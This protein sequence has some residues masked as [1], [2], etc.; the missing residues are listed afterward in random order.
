[1]EIDDLLEIESD[2]RILD[3]RFKHNN[4]PM[5]LYVRHYLFLYI[6][7]EYYN[8]EN[9]HVKVNPYL[10]PL[11]KKLKYLWSVLIRH[12]FR[13]NRS[14]VLII[15]SSVNCVRE[16]DIYMNK[17]YDFILE[18]NKKV[19]LIETSHKFIFPYPR[20]FENQLLYYDIILILSKSI[21]KFIKIEVEDIKTIKNFVS[22]LENRYS[23]NSI[24]KKDIEDKLLILS[25]RIKI[26]TYLH[27]KL[28]DLIKPI[29]LIIEDAHY[30]GYT[31]VIDLAKRNNIKV[32]EIQHGLVNKN[33]LAYNY[34]KNLYEGI[35]SYLPDYFLV[36]GQYFAE[37]IRIPG[38]C[39]VIGKDYLNKK[40]FK[41]P[42]KKNIDILVI[43]SG[44]IPNF[45]VE[46]CKILKKEFP[47]FKILFRPHPSE[48]PAL[49]KRY[50]EIVQMNID[51][52]TSNLYERLKDCDVVISGEFSTV[53]LEA[54]KYIQKV[55]LVKTNASNIY[56]EK[57][58]PFLIAE[59][60]EDLIYKIEKREK[61]SIKSIEYLWANNARDRFINFLQNE[62]RISL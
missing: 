40:A 55:Y 1:M 3:F 25:K 7:N 46:L 17:I 38:K 59:N 28:F 50:K 22:F 61:A 56:I 11:S 34:H 36:F 5:W 12:P 48:R 23:L 62:L 39:I 51:I 33:H 24:I 16:N 26:S 42:L 9:P 45:Y 8:L 30:G 32:A 35:K 15:G 27:Q 37:R 2:P 43:S 29:L 52:D 54:I 44:N 6:L 53:I 49:E 47:E 20:L 13:K 57:D 10:L 60:L 4:L 31:E 58:E 18:M 19:T 41:L 14:E 21:R